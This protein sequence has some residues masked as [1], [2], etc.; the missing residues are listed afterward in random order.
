MLFARLLPPGI[1]ETPVMDVVA[2]FPLHVDTG[3]Q[4]ERGVS[5]HL[6]KTLAVENVML[7]RLSSSPR[8]T[9]KSSVA[10]FSHV[11]VSLMGLGELT[12]VSPYR[13]PPPSWRASTSSPECRRR[14]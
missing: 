6:N 13:R 2:A 9:P 8:S 3:F 1:V 14:G 4:R 5:Q 7:R 12:D 11:N 10:T